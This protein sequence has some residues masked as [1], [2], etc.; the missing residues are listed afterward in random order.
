MLRQAKV[1]QIRP[2]IRPHQYVAGLDIAVNETAIMSRIQGRRDRAKYAQR[3]VGF[4]AALAFKHPPQIAAF[5]IAHREEQQSIGLTR[6]IDRNDIRVLKPSRHTTLAKKPR[7]KPLITR[8]FRWQHL[9]SHRAV[10]MLVPSQVNHAD[11][12]AAK[13]SL[14]PIPGQQRA[15]WN[16]KRNSHFYTR[17]SAVSSSF[18]HRPV[19]ATVSNR[20]PA[21]GI[22]GLTAWRSVQQLGTPP[23]VAESNCRHRHLQ[24]LEAAMAADLGSLGRFVACVKS[25]GWSSKTSPA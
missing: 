8:Q 1:R 18:L 2:I 16:V 20:I 12:A 13:Q 15:D 7:P 19:P 4:K 23:N 11:R 3:T 21:T 6:R 5:D 9:D 25:D 14:D 10:K 24:M 22:P 17:R